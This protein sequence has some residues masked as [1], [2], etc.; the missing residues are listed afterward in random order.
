MSDEGLGDI[1]NDPTPEPVPEVLTTHEYSVLSSPNT[2]LTVVSRTTHHSLWGHMLWNASREAAKSVEEIPDLRNKS[3]LEIGAGLGLP[4]LVAASCGA[5]LVVVSDYPDQAL[6]SALQ[7]NVDRNKSCFNPSTTISVLGLQWG[8]MTQ[9]NEAIALNNGKRFDVVILSDVVFNHVCHDALAQTVW[10]TLSVDG[11][12]LCPFTHHRPHKAVEDMKFINNVIPRCQLKATKVGEVKYPVMF[13]DDP[14]DEEVRATVHKYHIQHRLPQDELFS[15][16]IEDIDGVKVI[17]DGTDVTASLVAGALARAGLKVLHLDRNE[18]YGGTHATLTLKQFRKLAMLRGYKEHVT[19]DPA[20]FGER[21]YNIDLHPAVVY[22]DGPLVNFF[23]DSGVGKYLEFKNIDRILAYVPD[24]TPS[25]VTVPLC[26]SDMFKSQILTLQEKRILMK[27]VQSLVG[28]VGPEGT[29]TAAPPAPPGMTL[30]E[31]MK[32]IGTTKRLQ[33]WLLYAVLNLT[34]DEAQNYSMADAQSKMR[35]FHGSVGKYGPT[36]FITYQFG[37]AEFPQACCRVCAVYEGIYILRR[38]VDAIRSEEGDRVVVES[39]AQPIQTKYVVSSMESEAPVSS[40]SSI[41]RLVLFST[42]P[43]MSWKQLEDQGDTPEDDTDIALR[44]EYVAPSAI[45]VIPPGTTPH[46]PHHVVRVIQGTH[47]T[48][49]VPK[50]MYVLQFVS[51]APREQLEQL[52]MLLSKNHLE[53][54]E[55]YRCS[56]STA[57]SG[58]AADMPPTSANV[59]IAPN[60]LSET[61][62]DIGI[63]TAAQRIYERIAT[64][65]GI[66]TTFYEKLPDPCGGGNEG[67]GSDA[68]DEASKLLGVSPPAQPEEPEQQKQE[69]EE[70]A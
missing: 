63:L 53:N 41:S 11:I 48:Q 14:G 6:L 4:S 17:V 13:K 60:T 16:T 70:N 55:V 42:T 30:A 34:D 39:C 5:R 40:S 28:T 12:A 9:I 29:L 1:F 50:G 45:I 57:A 65:E 51:K 64:K 35:L 54:G 10:E 69:T 33:D 3:V 21:S 38:G 31:F 47:N 26:K 49:V 27:T 44:E 59:V 23:V 25:F 46:N 20:G 18:Y 7:G 24:I 36:P 22:S 32:S 58:A 62:D 8:N 61:F 43:L 56:W 15:E 2:V 68:L 66:T 67:D 19:K 52:A 37:A